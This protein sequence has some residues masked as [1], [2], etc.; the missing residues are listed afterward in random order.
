MTAEHLWSAWLDDILGPPSPNRYTFR[1]LEHDGD[2]RHVIRVWR[3]PTLNLTA[4]VACGHCN[5]GW[6]SDV[7][8]Q[9]AK[10]TI[11]DMVSRGSPVSLLPRGTSS[12]AVFTFLK[13]VVADHMNG[14]RHPFFRPSVRHRFATDLMIP[15]GVQIWLGSFRGHAARRGLLNTRYLQPRRGSLTGFEFYVFTY[16]INF[17]ALQLV[18]SR[19]TKPA[20]RKA[21]PPRLTTQ[22]QIWD[23]A[24]TE[25]WPSDGMA[26]IWPLPHALT[27]QSFDGFCDRWRRL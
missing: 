24:A 7:E 12:I 18:A 16:V 2:N 13:A 19:W 21:D 8:N 9:H 6:M 26:V 27:D 10:P 25:I 17:V 3:T 14:T 11:K 22:A 4:N 1:K 23:D 20:R 5:S 15:N